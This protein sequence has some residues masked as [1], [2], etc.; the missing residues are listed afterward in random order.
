MKTYFM[1]AVTP[2]INFRANLFLL[3]G[4][5]FIAANFGFLQLSA[6]QHSWTVDSSVNVIDGSNPLYNKL[7]P[8]DTIYI[9]AGNRDKLLIR[10]FT[11][12]ADSAVIFINKNGIVNISTNDYY[13]ISINNC[14]YIRF[15][16]NGNSND[17]YGI[18]IKKVAAGCGI[19]IGALSSDV[20]IDHVSITNCSTEGIYAKTDPDCS[21]KAT[22]G[23]FTQ[24]NTNIHDNYIDN[25][26]NEGMYIGSS[27]Y[28][29]L[30]I[31]CNGKDTIVLPP[32]L[33]G[34]S[35]YN[36]TVKNTG[37]DGIQVSSAPLH[38]HIFNN[39]IIND[40]QAET[41]NQMSG[42]LMGG[43]TKCNC[44]N[45]LITDGK[46]DGIENH[47]LGGNSIFNN[48]IVN[49]GKTYLPNNLTQMKHGIFVSDVSTQQDSSVS[50]F[51]NDI[52]N[53]K[54]DGIRFQSV[55]SRHNLISGN[56]IVNPGNFNLYE[57]D[58][59][60]FTGNDAY[61]MIPSATADVQIK[62][63]Y[64]SRSV[65][66]A[67]IS[68]ADYTILAGSPLINTG[69]AGNGVVTFDFY[70]HRRPVGDLFDIGAVEYAGGVDTLLHTSSD[71]VLLFP[72]PVSTNLN[73][74]YLAVAVTASTVQIY[75]ANGQLILQ[76]LQ[77]VTVP[78]IQQLHINVSQLP[79]GLYI[80]I[81]EN[82]QHISYGKFVKQ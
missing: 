20:E 80:Y 33:D 38:C 30:T 78:G 79:C 40:S 22:R 53:P 17:A 82:G 76:T 19:G 10:N 28:A 1:K 74:Q 13:G 73:I 43:G 63:N 67:K 36:N 11:G 66:A 23:N 35:I 56:L 42:I 58:N 68:S 27:Y 70:N 77:Q 21:L 45:N 18:Q 39:T 46:G 52:I 15:T 12:T 31:T 34:I 24:F 32:V 51:F 29:G 61:V 49:A 47:G 72:N 81:F 16:G 44:N 50:I 57:T 65:A 64:F 62:N 25:I 5:F 14:R 4:C 54:S 71:K 60:P 9:S 37:W 59:T 8:G 2:K 75:A 6:Q 69:D 41:P 3:R 55:K 7:H 48:I 26:G